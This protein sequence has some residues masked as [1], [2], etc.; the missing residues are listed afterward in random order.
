MY[1]MYC[2]YVSCLHVDFDRSPR[3][4]QPTQPWPYMVNGNWLIVDSQNPA[5]IDEPANG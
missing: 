3:G 4:P 5:R 2:M 1:C